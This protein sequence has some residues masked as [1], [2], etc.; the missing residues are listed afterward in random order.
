V[1]MKMLTTFYSSSLLDAQQS[2]KAEVIQSSFSRVNY[3]EDF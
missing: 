2:T 1:H 3:A